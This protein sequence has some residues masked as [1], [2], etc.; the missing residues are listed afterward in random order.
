MP[1]MKVGWI[2]PPCTMERFTTAAT[3]VSFLTCSPVSDLC[4]LPTEVHPK[5]HGRMYFLGVIHLDA[6][7]ITQN[8]VLQSHNLQSCDPKRF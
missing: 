8:H 5:G 1:G 3:D 4:M 6:S 7:F 2:I